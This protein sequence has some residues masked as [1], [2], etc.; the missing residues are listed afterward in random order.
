MHAASVLIKFVMSYWI[1]HRFTFAGARWK[2]RRR[3][4]QTAHLIFPNIILFLLKIKVEH[5]VNYYTIYNYIINFV[6]II[7]NS[8]K[9]HKFGFDWRFCGVFF[10]RS[11]LQ[12]QQQDRYSMAVCTNWT[13]K[14][15]GY[16]FQLGFAETCIFIAVSAYKSVACF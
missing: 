16:C 11:S 10:F 1:S 12:F 5:I 8:E 6:C 4:N 3:K 15:Y 7:Y 13:D 14:I 2:I 9:V